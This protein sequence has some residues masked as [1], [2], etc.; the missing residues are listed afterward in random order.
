MKTE[1]GATLWAVGIS[2]TASAV[3]VEVFGIDLIL[4]IWTL[5]GSLTAVALTRQVSRVQALVRFTLGFL[6][7]AVATPVAINMVGHAEQPWSHKLIALTCGAL[8]LLGVQLA[9]ERLPQVADMAME[10][11]RRWIPG[12]SKSKED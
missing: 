6:V 10:A 7:G 1:V 12:T 9:I 5:I 3:V 8:T 11:L 2:S 4:L